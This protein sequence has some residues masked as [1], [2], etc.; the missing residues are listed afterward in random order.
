MRLLLAAF[1]LWLSA[2]AGDPP[3]PEWQASAHGSLRSFQA[4]YL[5]GRTLAAEQEFARARSALMRC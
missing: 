2:C 3:A 5:A 4:A 1:A